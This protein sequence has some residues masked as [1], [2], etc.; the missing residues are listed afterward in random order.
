[1][2]MHRNEGTV[3]VLDYGVQSTHRLFVASI[4]TSLILKPLMAQGRHQKRL[5]I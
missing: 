3:C 1:M 5:R 4:S 2:N